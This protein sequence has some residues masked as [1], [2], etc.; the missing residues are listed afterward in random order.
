MIS[1]KSYEKCAIY[2]LLNENIPR[3]GFCMTESHSPCHTG[4]VAKQ[5]AGIRCQKGSHGSGAE[6]IAASGTQ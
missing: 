4:S 5:A 3:Q 6:L 1:C 2:S